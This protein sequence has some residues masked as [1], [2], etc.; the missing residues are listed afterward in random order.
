MGRA[1]TL[2]GLTVHEV[3]LVDVPANPGALHVL[4]K[5]RDPLMPTDPKTSK[6]D[7]PL[8]RLLARIGLRKSTGS[9]PLSFEAH[10]DAASAAVDE[11]VAA[12]KTS[13]DS[14]L[15]DEAVADKNAAIVKSL[16]EFRA[17]LGESVPDQIEK[18]MRD[19][20]QAATGETGKDPSMA[21]LEEQIA[22]LTKRAEDAEFELAKAKLSP[23]H[24]KYMSDKGMSAE[25]QKA[26]AAK[27]P[28]D[29][30][31]QMSGNPVSKS[32]G[33]PSEEL[34]KA[35]EQ[36][37]DLRK[38]V[39]VFEAEKELELMKRRAVEIGVGEARAETILKASKGD[40]AAFDEVL[41]LL[42]A[43][44]TQAATAKLFG[45]Y[46]STVGK[47]AGSAAAEVE[48]K[49]EE[50]RKAD[51]KLSLIAARVQVRKSHPDLAQRERTEE[52]AALH[53][54]S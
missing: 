12:L 14:I 47:A 17:Y 27:S 28:E 51:P 7:G 54:V 49:A 11:A 46:G 13:I 6:T 48:A 2:K 21:T 24:A 25:Q 52:R 8:D 23:A 44:N 53:A 37:E 34:R 1:H 50:L 38:R 35:L 30:D 16:A 4:F 22:A 39:A 18:A 9:A 41:G 31:A 43:S 40:A 32:A 26:F 29:R 15:A 36:Q 33:E 3:S 5:R 20:A 42:K 45:E 10:A 19:V